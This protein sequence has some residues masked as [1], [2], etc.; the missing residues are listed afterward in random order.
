M[1]EQVTDNLSFIEIIYIVY[2]SAVYFVRGIGGYEGQPLFNA[3][4]VLALLLFGVKVMLTKHTVS[5]Y[6]IIALLMLLG[7][8]IYYK[9]GE[10][11]FLLNMTMLLG[12]KDIDIKKVL[13]IVL[14]I[15][16]STFVVGFLLCLTGVLTPECMLH[17]KNGIGYIICYGMIYPHPN[18]FHSMFL[19]I[20]A[21]IIYKIGICKGRKLLLETII[22]FSAN[23]YVFLY[24]FSYTGFGSTMLLILL[25][26]YFQSRKDISK[27]E[28]I[29]AEMI[30]PICIIFSLVGP[31][32]IT[33][34]T[35]EII[36][37]ML[38]TRYNLSRYFL[39]E[40]PVSLF[41]TRFEVPNYTYNI[42]CSYVYLF[43]QM[44]IVAFVIGVIGYIVL[45]HKLISNNN[46]LELAITLA[47]C[48]AG[49]AEPFLFNSSFKNITI[50]FMGVV[51]YELT[52][53]LSNFSFLIKEIQILPQ[54]KIGLI[55]KKIGQL[56]SNALDR[57]RIFSVWNLCKNNKKEIGIIRAVIVAFI[58]GGLLAL[59]YLSFTSNLKGVF[60]SEEVN[61]TTSDAP[62]EYMTSAE[63]TEY[64]NEGYEIIGY[65]SATDPLYGY[66]G[67]TG[68]IEY[69]RRVISI[70][71]WS[72]AAML[73]V[74]LVIRLI[75]K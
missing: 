47:F 42:D 30:F 39:T 57:T 11:W 58:I 4:L 13:N 53:K 71:V 34:R 60:V 19:L 45:I 61:Q 73:S 29:I 41:G 66:F 5:E 32:T 46:R 52:S 59:L 20:T 48:I 6:I 63:A 62:V 15:L 27:V 1:N 8:I 74:I 2:I 21:L 70:Y 54:E 14:W 18:S 50:M 33:G 17:P 65:T 51:L 36:N 56:T 9:T 7:G 3:T 67:I 43:M 38:S 72:V 23:I 24:S 55:G 26:A 44:G 49:I 40:Q 68:T 22:L 31:V 37:K 10:K 12:V 16:L 25:N 64:V 69:S 35:F 75:K 28:Y